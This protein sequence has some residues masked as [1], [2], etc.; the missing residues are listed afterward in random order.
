MEVAR[1]FLFLLV[2]KLTPISS[3]RLF[4]ARDRSDIQTRPRDRADTILTKEY[5]QNY[6]FKYG[7]I[8][9]I[10]WDSL[11]FRG[12]PA[13]SEENVAPPDISTLL[14]EGDSPPSPQPDIPQVPEP[15]LN[16][17][18]I[19]ALKRFQ[20]ANGLKVTGE[21]DDATREA[22][23][24]P[25]C[26]VPDRKVTEVEKLDVN[27]LNDDF[28]KDE[29]EGFHPTKIP[30]PI[31]TSR[32]NS[33]PQ[34]EDNLDLRLSQHVRKKRSHLLKAAK[35]K[36][37]FSKP[38][39][40]WRLLGEGYSV[41]L[42]IDQQRSILMRAFRIWSEVVPLDFEEDLTSPAHLIDIKLGFG[43]RRH[44]GCSQL[45]DGMGREFA[46]AW[47]L[48]DI[49]FDD[50]EHFVPPNSEQGI[51]LLKVAVHEIGH[52][53]GLSH[54]NEVKSVMQPNYIPA[55]S[56]MELDTVD[57]RAIQK[58]YG[59]CSGRFNTVFD[60]VHQDRNAPGS[61]VF[62]TYFFRKG[63]YWMYENRSNRTR[64]RDPRKLASGWKGIPS[65][66]IDAFIHIWTRDKDLTL[67]FKGTQYWRYD[68]E[69]DRAYIQDPEGITYPRLISEGF[70][71]ITGPIDT[72]YYDRRDKNVY[73]FRGRN[74]TA[75]NVANHRVVPG[76]PKAIIDVFPPWMS[77]DHPLSDLDAVYFSFTYQTVFFIKNTYVWRLAKSTENQDV[78]HNA[79]LPRLPIND[80]WFDICDVHPSM[81]S[82]PRR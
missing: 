21:L 36:G 44:L 59:R 57:R 24:A 50:D 64:Y 62:Q 1:I 81:L 4:H 58:I 2:T 18:F 68:N 11:P 53:L 72:A 76:Y 75:F 22:M 46:H 10:R 42:T 54:M 17:R 15:T 67:F 41:W 40:K 32:T 37:A 26:G 69:N 71:G 51:S 79:L 63:W 14:S 38:T 49:H 61:W 13:T 27:R 35:K 33:P 56:K 3:E 29:T 78:P 30:S 65:S 25:R 31:I 5:A 8:E 16:P 6:L 55:N 73:F 7:W 45:F 47:Q 80:Q 20:E 43:T 74:V 70:P 12:V 39:I 52:V 9:P 23:N 60:W 19:G 82:I 28:S 34:P 48:G 66:D 77:G